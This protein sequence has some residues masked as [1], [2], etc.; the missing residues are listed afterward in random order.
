MLV[1]GS[2]S[3]DFAFLKRILDRNP[4]IELT[5]LVEKTRQGFYHDKSYDDQRDRDL[6]ILL[7]YPTDISNKQVLAS[8]IDEISSGTPVLLIP[9]LNLRGEYLNEIK[10]HLPVIFKRNLAETKMSSGPIRSSRS[11]GNPHCFIVSELDLLTARRIYPTDIT[12]IAPIDN[13]YFAIRGILEHDDRMIRH[14]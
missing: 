8:I 14:V 3:P 1:A 9:G 2:P 5:I 4:D 10:D 11:I 7:D 6:F 13:V 12:V